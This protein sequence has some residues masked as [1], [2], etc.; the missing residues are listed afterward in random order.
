M[1]QRTLTETL[2]QDPT[3]ATGYPHGTRSIKPDFRPHRINE[4]VPA[5]SG[6]QGTAMFWSMPVNRSQRGAPEW[7]KHP[8][9]PLPEHVPNTGVTHSSLAGDRPGQ[10]VWRASSRKVIRG[11]PAPAINLRGE[12]RKAY[13]L[14]VLTCRQAEPAFGHALVRG[15]ARRELGEAE[16]REPHM[17]E[18][19]CRERTGGGTGDRGSG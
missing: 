4:P 15:V 9:M 6:A 3:A 7:L 17:R 1:H 8:L 5:F 13:G 16:R 19:R 12:L 11:T 10:P 18:L 2:R 14:A